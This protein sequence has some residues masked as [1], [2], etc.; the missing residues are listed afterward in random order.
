[1]KI[2]LN[3]DQCKS[4]RQ[5]YCY[6]CVSWKGSEIVN[7]DEESYWL[8]R[9]KDVSRVASCSAV[10][11]L[12]YIYKAEDVCV[13]A[14]VHLCV[15]MLY[16]HVHISCPISIKLYTHIANLLFQVKTNFSISRPLGLCRKIDK[17]EGGYDFL[18]KPRQSYTR[19]FFYWMFIA[20]NAKHHLILRG[21]CRVLEFFSCDIGFTQKTA[22]IV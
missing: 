8:G 19:K 12:F 21:L 16:M 11:W 4:V 5:V 1:M 6:Q 9:R 10:I 18:E 17:T 15:F 14:C 7:I 3:F 2:N 20:L 13:C 22:T